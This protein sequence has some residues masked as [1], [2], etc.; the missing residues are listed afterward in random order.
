MPLLLF[1][2]GASL[3]SFLHAASW[4]TRRSRNFVTARSACESC[5]RV[6]AAWEIVPVVGWL[7]LRGRCRHCHAPIPTHHVVVEVT[8]GALTMLALP[9][10]T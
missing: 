2:G 7:A 10:L 4:R 6:L 8:G 1:V 5:D 9:W 3:A